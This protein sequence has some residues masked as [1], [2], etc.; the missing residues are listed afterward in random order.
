[1]ADELPG[2]ELG[3]YYISVTTSTRQLARDLNAAAGSA[4]TGAGQTAGDAYATSF[5][6]RA[7]T[8]LKT[9][10]AAG[11]LGA[12]LTLGFDR[13]IQIDTAEAKLRGLGYT[14]EQIES[15]MTSALDAVRGTAYGLGD[16]ATI[17]ASALAAGVNEGAELTQYLRLAAD[18]AAITGDSLESVGSVL[19]NVRT[20]NTAYNDSLQILAQR[21][22]PVY[23]L[24]ADS[25][26]VTTAEVKELAS[27]GQITADVLEEA[28]GN[29]VTGAALEMGETIT[30]SWDNVLA[31][32]SRIGANLLGTTVEDLP[33]FLQDVQ[34]N[35]APIEDI[36]RGVGDAAGFVVDVFGLIPG[37][38]LATAAALLVLQRVRTST[39]F[40]DAVFEARHFAGQ[41][42]IV[43]AQTTMTG[44]SFAAQ[45]SRIQAFT[46]VVRAGGSALLGAFG[47]PVGL[48]VGGAIALV[49]TALASWTA[50]TEAQERATRTLSGTLDTNTGKVTE[51]TKQSL[52]D[53]LTGADDGGDNALELIDQLGL[54]YEGLIDDIV[55]GS[56]EA[57][58]RVQALL[59]ELDKIKQGE[60]IGTS[61]REE[62]SAAFYAYRELEAAV[63]GLSDADAE[64]R[65]Q[66]VA[67]GKQTRQNTVAVDQYEAAIE[68]AFA[69]VMRLADTRTAIADLGGAIAE[70]GKTVDAETARGAANV[71]Q[72]SETLQT[73]AQAAGE[74]S[75]Q[76]GRNAVALVRALEQQGIDTGPVL[77]A[78][79]RSVG[80][81]AGRKWAILLDG[82]QAIAE[83]KAVARANLAAARTLLAIATSGDD[84]RQANEAISRAQAELDE[85]NSIQSTADT[86]ARQMSSAANTEAASIDRVSTSADEATVSVRDL[87]AAVKEFAGVGGNSRYSSEA[88]SVIEKIN[89][90]VREGTV[91]E[92]RGERLV[93]Q[94]KRADRRM[95]AIADERERLSRRLDR[96]NAALDQAIAV[97]RDF[98]RQ[99]RDGYLELG[100]LAALAA[101][102]ERQI[103]EYFT[104][105]DTAFS[106]TRTQRD[107]GGLVAGLRD[108]VAE[109]QEFQ[110]A[111][112]ALVAAG[113]GDS[114]L[115]Q[116]V[117][118]FAQTGDA[119]LATSLVGQ[120][121]EVI[122]EIN[123]LEEQLAKSG[124][125]LGTAAGDYLYDAGIEAKRGIVEG[126]L[127]EDKQLE[128]AADHIADTLVDRVKKKLGIKSPSTV[129]AEQG[130]FTTLGF[131]RGIESRR[132][133]LV[134]AV[135]R[136]YSVPTARAA[137]V[138]P[139]GAAA[140]GFPSKVAL[141]DS[142][143]DL[144]AMV[145]VRIQDFDQAQGVTAG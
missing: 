34:A 138:D 5:L 136:L 8:V 118:D 130:A 141:V 83:A 116:L 67:T 60:I 74:D 15:V 93:A 10:I 38:V 124:K 96:A 101:D 91:G 42:G 46:G 97:R 28:L 112:D 9:A 105:G 54:S 103:T 77:E 135:D 115:E 56:P 75:D 114:S 109:A 133:D 40:R 14:G 121:P 94:V 76:Y 59:A 100:N 86:Y 61:T 107:A 78:V 7:G 11:A 13:L 26:G 35:L 36:A 44:A 53:M 81:I 64:W 52:L 110:S 72:I 73:L 50:A 90:A 37:P 123:G 30:G 24:L 88:L 20:L 25:L 143:G 126:L 85:L 3:T 108:R 79:R 89:T 129:L 49:T 58:L 23:T 4:G 104:E 106:V 99:V 45:G 139:V 47:G 125:K 18:T 144:M 142:N 41:M 122:E 92:G 134:S 17:A 51:A 102:S 84:A 68:S 113:L 69:Q 132:A 6:G 63:G 80:A 21:G 111:Y 140:G 70:N 131:V 65:R 27:E 87:V 19:N 137:S 127:A 117:L 43:R 120:G 12:P 33:Q 1:M 31:S 55:S 32:L 48:A 57:Q 82:S 119:S 39:W 16:A 145:D 22:L 62:A 29:Q 128:K 95:Q 66:Q 2:V 71:Q 98:V